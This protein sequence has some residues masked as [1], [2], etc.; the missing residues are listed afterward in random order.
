MRKLAPLFII[1]VLLSGYV[2]VMNRDSV[3]QYRYQKRDA[4]DSLEA[5][6]KFIFECVRKNDF[7]SYSKR[8]AT[9]E[10]VCE[11]VAVAKRIDSTKFSDADGIADDIDQKILEQFVNLRPS[12]E[13]TYADGIKKGID[14]KNVVY[15]RTV[16]EISNEP[17]FVAARIRIYFTHAGTRY[18]LYLRDL[19]MV[20]KRWY[21]FSKIRLDDDDYLDYEGVD[22]TVVDTIAVYP[23]DSVISKVDSSGHDFFRH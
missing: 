8:F 22:S 2:S 6:S 7:G 9:K 13:K 3:P 12:F 1:L 17:G 15:T 20:G 14:W 21:N 23:I 10:Q 18:E 19:F 4:I 11:L 16:Y 5:F